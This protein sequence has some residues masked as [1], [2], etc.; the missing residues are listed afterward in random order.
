LKVDDA[1]ELLVN[2]T[3]FA[4]GH[5]QTTLSTGESTFAHFDWQLS[6]LHA[7]ALGHRPASICYCVDV[8]RHLVL[9]RLLTMTWSGEPIDGFRTNSRRRASVSF[10]L[11]RAKISALSG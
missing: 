9:P 4:P 3:S 10:M 1:I 8:F 5:T 6:Y 7:N 11:H 2:D